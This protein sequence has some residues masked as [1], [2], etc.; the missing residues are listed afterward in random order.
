[1]SGTILDRPART[2]AGVISN[3]AL[4][5]LRVPNQRNHY[6]PGH[7]RLSV[8]YILL[9]VQQV[10]APDR[11]HREEAAEKKT[12]LH[13]R[14]VQPAVPRVAGVSGCVPH[15]DFQVPGLL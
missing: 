15:C 2:L 5:G 7:I 6:L 1:M 8:S 12:G 4:L 14:G 13:A 3:A 11:V 10:R 9:L